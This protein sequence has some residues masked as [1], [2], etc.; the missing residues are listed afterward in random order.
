M[1]GLRDLSLNQ[2][3]LKRLGR[4]QLFIYDKDGSMYL[5]SHTFRGYRLKGLSWGTCNY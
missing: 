5:A 2:A 3:R 4:R 1:V